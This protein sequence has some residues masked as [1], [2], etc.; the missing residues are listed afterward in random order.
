MH[1]VKVSLGDRSYDIEIGAGLDKIGERLKDLG[2]GQK[3]ALVTNPT[4]KKLYGSRAWW[5]VS[6]R[7]GSWS[8]PSRSPMASSI[9]TL[10][11][12]MPYIPRS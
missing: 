9:R 7:Q 11:G 10:T 4:V 5:T 6:R 1:T 2:F 8:C 3:M 12:P